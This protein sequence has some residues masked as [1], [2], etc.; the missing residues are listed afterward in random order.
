MQG[1]TTAN[2]YPALLFSAEHS[3]DLA[4]AAPERSNYKPPRRLS[5]GKSI[6]ITLLCKTNP[7]YAF[8]RPK[9][10]IMRKNKPKQTQFKPNSKPILTSQP[11][12][13]AKTNPIKPNSNPKTKPFCVI[14]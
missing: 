14:L 6:K 2:K 13:K 9:I 8:F 10:A 3:F 4:P 11:P 7:I 1:F 12:I 5:G